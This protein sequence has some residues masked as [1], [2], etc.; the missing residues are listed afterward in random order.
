MQSREEEG[1]GGCQGG[2]WKTMG[3]TE[4][5]AERCRRPQGAA[6]TTGTMKGRRSRRC[7]RQWSWTGPSGWLPASPRPRTPSAS[8]L[9]TTHTS[10]PSAVTPPAGTPFSV[11]PC[12]G[13]AVGRRGQNLG[14]VPVLLTVPPPPGLAPMQ[15]DV[16]RKP[17]TSILYGNGPG[18][19]IVAGERENVSAVDFGE[20]LLG[21]PPPPPIVTA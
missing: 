16:D 13:H 20:C 3:A 5:D 8:S 21:Q 17:F 1:N 11:S 18:Y 12:H 15:S 7:T 4:G 14:D 6:S 10:S 2:G 9:P 19:K